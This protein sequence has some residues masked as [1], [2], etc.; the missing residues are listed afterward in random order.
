MF[1]GSSRWRRDHCWSL[2]LTAVMLM[3]WGTLVVVQ[4]AIIECAV[5]PPR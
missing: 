5:A 2:V 1:S 3:S 4:S